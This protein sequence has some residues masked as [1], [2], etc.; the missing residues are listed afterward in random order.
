M[1]FTLDAY[2]SLIKEIKEKQYKICSY[3]DCRKYDKFVI[4]R[5]DVDFEPAKAVEMAEAEYRLGVKSVYFFL[6][7]SEFY[8][9]LSVRNQ[10]FIKRIL[11]CGHEIGLHFDETKYKGYGTSEIKAAIYDEIRLLE[12][13]TEARVEAVSMHRPSKQILESDLKLGKIINT[14]GAE[15]FRDIKYLS[16]ARMNWREDVFSII[17]EEKYDKIQLL[18]HAFWYEAE[19][20]TIEDRVKCFIV[21]AKEER[22]DEMSHNLRNFDSII[23]KEDI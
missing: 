2:S 22:F 9:V 1:K 11:E 14:Y 20:T 5:H 15:F 6:I 10:K 8:N 21:Q 3:K 23:K 16:D 7:G 19:E 17:S 18:T 13:M 12:A 4:L